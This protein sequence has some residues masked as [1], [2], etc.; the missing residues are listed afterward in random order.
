MKKALSN[1]LDSIIDKDQYTDIGKMLSNEISVGLN[2]TKEL[3]IE[4]LPDSKLMLLNREIIENIDFQDKTYIV[5]SVDWQELL[6]N[7]EI[8]S[9]MMSIHTVGLINPIYLQLREDGRYRI[10]SGYRRAVSIK[11]GILQ[12]GDEY[13]VEGQVIIVPSDY[14]FEELDVL[15]LNENTHREDL[16]ITD[17]AQK[18]YDRS[19]NFKI[20]LEELGE[21]YNLSIRQVSRIKNSFKYPTAIKNILND[22]SLSKA[23]ELNKIIKFFKYNEKDH[24]LKIE[25]LI[26]KYK[27]L[28][29]EELREELKVLKQNSKKDET[30]LEV[31]SS[32]K[33][34]TIKIFSQL[35]DKDLESI[36]IYIDK[37]L[38]RK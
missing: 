35:S 13:S 28:S 3:S 15:Q 10:V 6:E 30:Q 2:T 32:K 9:L 21:E 5:R 14:T 12:F 25:E 8:D 17:L 11:K 16:N 1:S 24:N 36:K 22:I 4:T 20:S 33:S 38:N 31:K 18:F 29:R 23:E 19:E 26:E 34:T 27:G 7:R 37:V